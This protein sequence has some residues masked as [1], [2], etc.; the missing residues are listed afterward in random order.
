MIICLYNKQDVLTFTTQLNPGEFVEITSLEDLYAKATFHLSRV[1]PKLFNGKIKF[2]T[3]NGVLLE[4]HE[5]SAYTKPKDTDLTEGFYFVYHILRWGIGGK[6]STNQV[7][8]GLGEPITGKSKDKEIYTKLSLDQ[9]II[10]EPTAFKGKFKVRGEA[11]LFPQDF[12]QEELKELTFWANREEIL[13]TT[14]NVNDASHMFNKG[15]RIG[16]SGELYKV[17]KDIADCVNF[18]TAQQYQKARNETFHSL[19]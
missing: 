11:K 5:A 19:G 6:S 16:L 2:F 18:S 7:L 14:P 17:K 1:P 10:L 8:N 9:V 4:E 13:K 15:G 3:D 12:T